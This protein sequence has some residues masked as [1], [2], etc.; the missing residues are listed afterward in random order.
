MSNPSTQA[1][2]AVKV[3][4]AGGTG[5]L[6]VPIVDA[7]LA[8]NYPVTVLTRK[9]SSKASKL[10]QNSNITVAEV[11]YSSFSSLTEALKG[12]TVVV[13]TLAT[14]SAGNQ[15]P[16][17]DAAVSAGVTR[18]IP[19]EFGSDTCNHKSAQLPVFKHKVETQE[20]LKAVVSENPSFSYTLI[21]NGAFLDW[22]LRVG[23]TV[24][25]S[26]HTATVYNGG[27]VP[28]TATNLGTVGKAVVGVIQHLSETANRAVYIQDA[29]VT[30][31][32][33]IQYAKDKDGVEWD[34]TAKSLEKVKE[35]SFTEL[36]KG[37]DAN[38]GTAV[39][40]FLSSAIFGEGY[41]GNYSDHLDNKLLGL[42]GITDLE[43][44]KLVESYL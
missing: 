6:G 38:I 29:L 35:E 36:A 26:K 3:A 11:D 2:M 41:G 43:V 32:Q 22:G 9:G 19:S 23:F 31:N 27:D 17:I 12:H 21:C 20:Y 4:V 15:N 8:T 14:A 24:N 13:S 5:N 33:L 16:L 18:F 34:I 42:E 25:P 1:K 7:L 10:R 30:Q 28:F 37:P 40:G 44:R 39:V